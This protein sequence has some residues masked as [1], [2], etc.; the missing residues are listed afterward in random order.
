MNYAY[1]GVCCNEIGN[2][3]AAVIGN[4]LS[5]NPAPL[6]TLRISDNEID[7]DGVSPFAEALCTNT[8][9]RELHLSRND[10]SKLEMY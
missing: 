7:D 1:F 10:V 2:D 8:N 6:K 4:M 3:G 5:T 9:L